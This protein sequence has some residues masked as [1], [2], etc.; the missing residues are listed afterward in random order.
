[1]VGG[2]VEADLFANA[3]EV[4]SLGHEL[5]QHDLDDPAALRGPVRELIE[6]R[7]EAVRRAFEGCEEVAA[8]APQAPGDELRRIAFELGRKSA[9]ILVAFLAALTAVDIEAAHD[10]HR[11]IQAELEGFAQEEELSELLDRLAEMPSGVDVRIGHALARPG[12]YTD[13]FGTVDLGRVFG[14]FAEGGDPFVAVGRRAAQYFSFILESDLD[15]DQEQVAALLAIPLVE[16]V[17]A[18]RPLTAHRLVRTT[19]DLF[20]AAAAVDREAVADLVDETASAGADV[21][22]ALSR[23]RMAFAVLAHPAEI[24]DDADE[25]GIAVHEAIGEMVEESWRL[26]A[27]VLVGLDDIRRGRGEHQSPSELTVEELHDRLEQSDRAALREFAAALGRRRLRHRAFRAVQGDFELQSSDD[28]IDALIGDYN[29]WFARACQILPDEHRERFRF[30]YEGNFLQ[31][32]VKD[33]FQAPGAPNASYNDETA[34]LGF[35]YWAHPFDTEFRGPLLTQR[36][37]LVEARQAVEGEGGFRVHL[38]LVER[39]ARRLPDFLLVLRDRKRDRPPFVVE[40]EHDLQ[41]LLHGILKLHFDDVWPED[42][43]P[44]RA[45][46]RSRIDFVL[47]VERLVVE[48]KMTRPRLGAREVGEELI[49]D[50]ERYRSHPDCAALIAIVYDPDQRIVNTRTL[51][52]DLS[53]TRDGLVIR[54]VVV[55]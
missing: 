17:A 48:A 28:E 47:K 21:F 23:L 1:M 29:E 19:Y 14:A 55:R 3:A 24:Y 46:G 15:A 30:E 52:A 38:E 25:L 33:F 45:G 5:A 22:G 40:D 54:V 35:A 12:V 2:L 37:I 9:R 11:E 31:N 51:E 26:Q 43:A 50:I 39:I 7:L 32:R 18:E 4:S 53:G 34:T 36:Q 44:E 27:R 16:V 6:G 13:P 42:Y 49:I 41:D 8:F 10:A 20:R